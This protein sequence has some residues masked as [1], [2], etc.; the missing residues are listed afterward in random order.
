MH[1]FSGDKNWENRSNLLVGY[2]KKGVIVEAK[3]N[4][5]VQAQDI[6]T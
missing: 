6:F 3:V 1:K 2:D 4:T 5:P